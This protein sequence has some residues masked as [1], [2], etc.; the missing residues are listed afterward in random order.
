VGLGTGLNAMLTHQAAGTRKIN[1]TALE[2]F[3]LNTVEVN[4][5][6]EAQQDAEKREWMQWLHELPFDTTENWKTNFVLE[7]KRL[8]IA[9]LEPCMRYD[10]IYF[11]AFGPRVAPD[12]WEASVLQKCYD[13]LKPGGIWVSYCAKGEV[14]RN[15][16]QAGFVTERLA[17]PPGK[18]EM[19]RARK[20]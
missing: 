14:R 9:D 5:L 6:L 16:Q 4:A 7:K 13:C 19:L 18:R 15:L 2:P 12:L 1:Y 3:P 17:G 20:N 10:V 8:G 11:D